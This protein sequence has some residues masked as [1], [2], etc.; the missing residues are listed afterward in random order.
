MT[1]AMDDLV[2]IKSPPSTSLVSTETATATDMTFSQAL[3]DTTGTD[4]VRGA[5]LTRR[6]WY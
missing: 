5:K 2:N 3:N 4:E 6:D 1:T